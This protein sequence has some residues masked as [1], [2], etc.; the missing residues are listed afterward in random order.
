MQPLLGSGAFS[1]LQTI[2]WDVKWYESSMTVPSTGIGFRLGVPAASFTTAGMQAAADPA[3]YVS[4]GAANALSTWNVYGRSPSVIDYWGTGAPV[5]IS[6]ARFVVYHYRGFL[7]STSERSWAHPQG[8]TSSF[9]LSFVGNGYI[10]VQVSGSDVLSS[11]LSPTEKVSSSLISVSEGARIDVYYWQLGEA[12]GGLVGKYVVQISGQSSAA[13]EIT[14]TQY[15]EAPVISA[16]MIPY[17][18][19]TEITLPGII[20]ANLEVSSPVDTPSMTF[21]VA[22]K[23]LITTYGWSLLE[24]PRRLRYTTFGGAPVYTLKR[25]QLISFYGPFENEQYQRF[26]G[27]IDG[28]EESDGIVTVSCVGQAERMAKINVE[29]YPDKISYA[30]FGYF[31]QDSSVEPIR[32]ITAYDQ[33]PLEHAIKDLCVRGGIDPKLFYG[34]RRVNNSNGTIT[35]IDDEV[36]NKQYYFRAKTLS[37]DLLQLQRP[38]RYGNAGAGFSSLRPSDDEYIYKPEVSKSVLDYCRELS[39]SLGYDFR[40]NTLGYVVLASRNNPQRFAKFAGGTSQISTTAIQGTYK[41]YTSPFNNSNTVNA[42]RVDLVVGRKDTLG[43]VNYSVHIMSG[44]QVASG[45]INL[46]LVGETAGVFFYDNRFSVDGS[47]QAVFQL[48]TGKWG[49]YEVRTSRNAGTIWLDSILQYDYDPFTTSLPESLLTD[50]TVEQLRTQ[51]N[52]QETANHV[53]VVGKRKAAITDS[54]K[55]GNPNNPEIEYYVAAGADPSSIW[56]T[57]ANNYVGGKVSILI[58]DQKISDQD[59]ANWAAQTL[60][61]R[62]RDPGPSTEITLPVVPVIE[63]RDPIDVADQAYQSVTSSTNQWVVSYSEEYT[64]TSAIMR[65]TTTTYSEIPSYEPRQDLAVATIDTTYAGQPVIN[66]NIQYPSIDSGTVTNPGH[67]LTDARIWGYTGVGISSYLITEKRIPNY[68]SDANGTYVLMSGSAAWPPVPDSIGLGEWR[69]AEPNTGKVYTYKNNPY[70][71][72]W[73]IYDYSTRKIHV[74]C[75]SGDQTANYTRTG[76]HPSSYGINTNTT[77]YYEGVDSSIALTSI[78]SGVSP[79]YDPYMSELPDGK[80]I[81]TSFDMLV[82]GFYRVSVWDARDRSNPTLVAWLTEAGEEDTSSEK[83]WTYFT[84]GK[85]RKFYWDGVDNIGE[86]NQRNSGDYSWA[87]RGWFEQE[88]RPTIGKGFYVWND[89][90]SSIVAISGQTLGSKLTFNPDKYSQF[91]VKVEVRNDKFAAEAEVGNGQAIRTV[92][93]FDLRNAPTQNPKLAVFIYTYLPPPNK[94]TLKKIEDWDPTVRAYDHE[95]DAY[96]ATGWTVLASGTGDSASSFRDS[97]PIRVTLEA[98]AR[99]GGRYSGNKQFTT[100]KVHRIAHLNALIM[101]QFVTYLGE[102]WHQATDSEQKRITSRKLLNTDKTT[103][104]AD[105]DWRRGDTLDSLTNTWVFRPQDFLI[106]V[107]GVTQPIEYC[108]YLQ[109]EDVPDFSS[110]RSVGETKSRFILAYMG[111]MFYLSVYTQDRSGRMAWAI[112]PTFID[113]SKIFGHSFATVFPED[114][115]GYATRTILGRQWVDPGYMDTLAT[116]WGITGGSDAYKY[117]QFYINRLE[118]HDAYASDPLRIDTNGSNVTGQLSTGFTD[119]YSA[120]LKTEGKLP[121]HY[122]TTKQLGTWSAGVITHFFGQWTWEGS[123]QSDPGGSAHEL[124]WLPDLTRDF[125]SFHLVPPMPFFYPRNASTVY[126]YFYLCTNFAWNGLPFQDAAQYDL[127]VAF[128]FTPNQATNETQRLRLS[129]GITVETGLTTAYKPM[130][131]VFNYVRQDDMMHWEEYRGFYSVGSAPTRNSVLVQ[132]SAG[133]YLV[134]TF[135]YEN[136]IRQNIVQNVT[137]DDDGDTIPNGAIEYLAR[138]KTGTQGDRGW[139]ATT[140]RAKYNWYSSSFFPTDLMHRLEPKYLY[141]KYSVLDY[142][143]AIHYDSGAWVGWKDDLPITSTNLEWTDDATTMSTSAPISIGP[144]PSSAIGYN[145][146]DP[147]YLF[148]A[149]AFRRARKPLAL[150]PRLPQSRDLI[151]SLSLVN[152]RRATPISGK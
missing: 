1:T 12:W 24:T 145:I 134:N 35:D 138:I 41:E 44:S 75:Q 72:F 42:A 96:S 8:T 76:T 123:A 3:G 140:F 110:H 86:W 93:S 49:K 38:S 147:R 32:D 121:S 118:S 65:I 17:S 40:T 79:F 11:R 23:D 13:T 143:T 77:V 98:V 60:L 116:K 105:T 67:N 88:Q 43:T 28:F 100:V 99:P 16:S 152:S 82:S 146:F 120:R 112:D 34:I 9:W 57:N 130:H 115:E 125:H 114:L 141:P 58:V 74:P 54:Q 37:G 107:D 122:I 106:E 127:W 27:Y 22:L 36:K 39:D 136:L 117:I 91:Y 10:R 85:A 56:D 19:A 71:K 73:H 46:A 81:E 95:V 144:A 33:W 59:Y 113:S 139:F 135:Q 87:A 50:K 131:N 48:Y 80:L 30:A 70:Q 4:S 61:T 149:N 47:N 90:T 29:N 78:Y 111:Y 101:D 150:G 103:D 104:Y 55:T 151:I 69:A 26:Y 129:P 63:P 89:L 6:R 84:A 14:T 2:A 92:N 53:V 51:A 108:D 45:T 97:K 66:F 126:A 15:R 94:V 109:L 128:A 7:S 31:S 124:L 102:P 5:G 119:K 83:H 52:S 133:A 137:A 20:S 21:R 62:Q 18:T 132:P 25:R 142:G 148:T 68:A 64:N